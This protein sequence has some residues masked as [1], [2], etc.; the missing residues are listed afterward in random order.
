MVDVS[1]PGAAIWVRTVLAVSQA[2]YH[3]TSQNETRVRH[4]VKNMLKTTKRFQSTC[5][6]VASC[7]T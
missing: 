2:D 1:I 4:E 7:S 3:D 6:G 5:H